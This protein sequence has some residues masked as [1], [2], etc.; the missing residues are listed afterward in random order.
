[1]RVGRSDSILFVHRSFSA[2]AHRPLAPRFF[3]CLES[4]LVAT[5]FLPLFN[6]SGH[7]ND[8]RRLLLLLCVVATPLTPHTYMR[9]C[10]ARQMIC[11][12]RGVET[13]GTRVRAPAARY[14]MHA[15]SSPPRATRLPVFCSTGVNVS[16]YSSTHLKH[17]GG[18]RQPPRPV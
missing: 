8:T 3:R 18:I 17:P 11:A 13:T 5:S 7:G 14:A 15:I 12:H 6:S 1:M 9:D 4:K 16:V 10:C 2:H